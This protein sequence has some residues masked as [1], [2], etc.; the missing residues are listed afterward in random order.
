MR[1]TLVGL[2]L[3]VTVVAPLA[4]TASPAAGAAGAATK[5]ASVTEIQDVP[6]DVPGT[7]QQIM[8]I[9]EPDGVG[10]YPAVILIHG[11]GFTSGDKADVQTAA[12]RIA[13][14]GFVV[15]APNYRLAPQN[16]FPAPLVDMKA[17]VQYVQMRG[18]LFDADPSRLGTMG[19]SAGGNLA[20]MV[21]YQSN[22]VR[23]VISW[24]GPTDLNTLWAD[25]VAH[26]AMSA[27]L[28]CSSCT[29][30]DLT[31]ASPTTFVTAGAPPSDLYSSQS[32]FVPT[33]QQT[34]L[35]SE[36][37]SVGVTSRVTVEPKGHAQGYFAVAIGPSIQFLQQYL[38]G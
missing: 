25:G 32:D 19:F 1:R 38:G 35:S 28:H 20:E 26:K 11:G 33:S 34:E 36:L 2:V 10:P 27:Y 17:A 31:P 12:D 24:S 7:T 6:Y 21:A 22:L 14:A 30:T 4:A 13:Q 16:A 37:S 8:D 3:A 18:S 9:Y 5:A 15:F 23:V 29:S